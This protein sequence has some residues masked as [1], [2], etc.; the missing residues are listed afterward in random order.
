[1]HVCRL[2][3]T[4][5][6]HH[7]KSICF[8]LDLRIVGPTQS[9]Q[10]VHQYWLMWNLQLGAHS[11]RWWMVNHLEFVTTILNILWCPLA[12]PMH[13]LSFNIWWMMFSIGIWMILCSITSMTSSFSQRTWQTIIAMYVLFWKSSKKLVFMPNWKSVNSINLRWNSWVILFLEMAFAWTFVRF[14]PLWIRLPQLMFGM[15]NVFLGLPTSIKDSCTLL[16]NND[17][18]YLSNLEGSTFS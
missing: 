8:A 7:Q 2:S 10:N 11:K 5:S 15:F 18:S 17:P 6:T 4:K 1:M 12:L 16:H 14:K 3:W 13:L 9:C